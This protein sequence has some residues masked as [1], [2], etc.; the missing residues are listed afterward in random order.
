MNQ[1]FDPFFL[2]GGL[3]F[4]Q[5]APIL[6]SPKFGHG[7]FR[8]AGSYVSLMLAAEKRRQRQQQLPVL[9]QTLWY[10]L[11]HQGASRVQLHEKRMTESAMYS[12]LL[13]EL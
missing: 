7:G 3:L 12:V 2:L 6:P 13:S 4:G 10:R 9:R 8:G 11:I 1:A 5:S